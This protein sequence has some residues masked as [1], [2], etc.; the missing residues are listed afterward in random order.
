[1]INSIDSDQTTHSVWS[2]PVC[3][4]ARNNTVK[5]SV[6]A[7]GINSKVLYKQIIMTNNFLAM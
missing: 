4:K 3:P 7:Y 6:H 5:V 2:K 1:M